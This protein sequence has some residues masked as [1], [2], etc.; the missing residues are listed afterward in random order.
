MFSRG[1]LSFSAGRK[2]VSKGEKQKKDFRGIINVI[3]CFRR[4]QNGK[5]E[6][7][8]WGVRFNILIYKYQYL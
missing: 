3:A 4:L 2:V 8:G 1:P 6:V 5:A 7:G